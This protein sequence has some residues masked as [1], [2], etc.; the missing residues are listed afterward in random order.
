MCKKILFALTILV[1][2]ALFLSA[3]H[4]GLNPE[5][6]IQICK[7]AYGKLMAADAYQMDY[8]VDLGQ[9][10]TY[11]ANNGNSLVRVQSAQGNEAW[12]MTYEGASYTKRGT[13]DLWIPTD[14]DATAAYG[15]AALDISMHTP[16]FKSSEKVDDIQVIV[17]TT[18]D[19]AVWTFRI[20]KS[21]DLHELKLEASVGADKKVATTY[22]F[23]H[24]N[25]A[26]IQAV[27]EDRIKELAP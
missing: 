7:D 5:E 18:G 22:F 6:Q 14:G 1:S 21:G 27:M 12:Y 23:Q 4:E 16:E 8:S 26:E 9:S 24:G 25:T 15:P 3:C 2:T 13:E 11:Y 10:G 20:D 17:L 19:D